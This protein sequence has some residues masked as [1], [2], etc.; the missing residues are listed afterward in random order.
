MP[1][2]TITPM[3]T[4][5]NAAAAVE[6]YKRAFGATEGERLTTPTG[7]IVAEVSID[8]ERFYVVDENP[9]AFNLSPETLG[10]RVFA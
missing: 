10:A 9:E 4:V 5:R 8:S 7:Q 1:S 3:L 6:F 2:S